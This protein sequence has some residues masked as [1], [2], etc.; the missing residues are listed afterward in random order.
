MPTASLN[1]RKNV[2][3]DTAAVVGQFADGPRVAEV[4][5]QRPESRSELRVQLRAQCVVVQDLEQQHVDVDDRRQDFEEARGVRFA[6]EARAEQRRVVAFT[7]VRGAVG[8]AGLVVVDRCPGHRRSLRIRGDA[9]R[10][11]PGDDVAV[12]VPGTEALLADCDVRGPA[13]GGVATTQFTLSVESTFSSGF[14]LRTLTAGL[15]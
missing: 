6:G 3:R 4:V 8:R 12:A 10:A 9:V 5:V 15:C 11:T 14:N 13:C 1:R 2:E 7:D